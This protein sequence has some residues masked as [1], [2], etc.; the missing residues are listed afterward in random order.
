VDSRSTVWSS[1]AANPLH[2]RLSGV[3]GLPLHPGLYPSP[4]L[5]DGL[6]LAGSAAMHEIIKQGAATFSF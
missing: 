4:D 6:T 2:E 1:T 5:I 3:A